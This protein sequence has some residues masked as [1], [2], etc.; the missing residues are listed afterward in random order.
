MLFTQTTHLR[1]LIAYWCL[2]A[3]CCG[4][5]VNARDRLPTEDELFMTL[6]YIVR[7]AK[8]Y[9]KMKKNLTREEAVMTELI[10]RLVLD[11]EQ[12]EAWP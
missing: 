2:L 7:C 3:K 8:D 1:K 10:D 11:S 5:P 9:E 4:L 6:A 12:E